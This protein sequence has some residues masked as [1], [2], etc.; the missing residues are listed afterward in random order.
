MKKIIQCA[1]ALKEY[2]NERNVTS[3]DFD[4][5]PFENLLQV[6]YPIIHKHEFYNDDLYF[7]AVENYFLTRIN[8]ILITE[9][10][11]EELIE[12]VEAIFVTNKE[13]HYIVF[14]LQGS[15]LKQDINFSKFH[16]LTQK[17]EEEI[18]RQLYGICGKNINESKLKEFINHTKRSRSK[19]FLNSNIM[20]IEIE[21]QTDNIKR[22]SYQMAQ[23][24]IDTIKLL[25]FAND[26]ESSIFRLA[27]LGQH[28]NKHVAIISK[29][30][31]RCGHGFSCDAHL[32]CKIDIDFMKNEKIQ[33]LFC[34]L[35]EKLT[36]K[37][38]D[39]L[40]NLFAN[41]FS[42]FARG[43]IHKEE[44]S[45]IEVSVLLYFAALES[46]FAEGFNEKRLRIASI[47]PR[48]INYEK[49][50]ISNLANVL[51]KLYLDRNNFLH[52]GRTMYFP[53]DNEKYNILQKIVAQVIIKWLNIDCFL[54][55]KDGEKRI[56]AWA[57]YVDSIFKDLIYGNLND[58]NLLTGN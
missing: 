44:N 58:I 35:Y 19:D 42:L 10:V 14:P 24:A 32:M 12:Y 2:C 22:S 37:N 38:G 55:I 9:S 43:V 40:D 53:N 52:A 23:L 7:Y 8:N 26:I 46:L 48:F 5:K 3:L 49:E 54:P 20:V 29:D 4:D 51:D 33:H 6:L 1:K 45:D 25:C 21:N 57:R 28:E 15:G 56:N 47:V 34:A 50:S 27:E 18:I 41:A 30:L 17:S 13:K 39:E 16:I 36:H 31:W 11:I